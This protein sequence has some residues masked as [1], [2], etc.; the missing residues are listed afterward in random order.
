MLRNSL[1]QLIGETA[2]KY[3]NIHEALHLTAVLKKGAT[4][5]S[6]T[7]LAKNKVIDANVAFSLATFDYNSLQKAAFQRKPASKNGINK[8]S[9]SI[10]EYDSQITTIIQRLGISNNINKTKKYQSLLTQ[11]RQAIYLDLVTVDNEQREIMMRMAGYWR[12]VN[13]RTYNAMV[14]R[15]ALWD[16]ATGAKL[17]EMDASDCDSDDD[18]AHERCTVSTRKRRGSGR[19]VLQR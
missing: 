7:S 12:Y 1:L 18:D 19:G 16:W 8:S 2:G 11:L 5:K 17:E 13:R 14:R 9:S 10:T 4:S 3:I 15:G 6:N